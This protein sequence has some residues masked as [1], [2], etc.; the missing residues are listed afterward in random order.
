MFYVIL[1]A[2][3]SRGGKVDKGGLSHNPDSLSA[4]PGIHIIGGENQLLKIII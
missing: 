1:K 4:T 2:W 3:K